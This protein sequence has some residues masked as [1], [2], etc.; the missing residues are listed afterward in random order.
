MYHSFKTYKMINELARIKS[1]W[2]TLTL[3][4]TITCMVIDTKQKSNVE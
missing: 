1:V 3:N 2:G 4:E